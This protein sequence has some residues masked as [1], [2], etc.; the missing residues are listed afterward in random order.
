MRLVSTFDVG[1]ISVVGFYS[2]WS[3]SFMPT[4]FDIDTAVKMTKPTIKDV[5]TIATAQLMRR[6]SF[7]VDL[8]LGLS[9]E[10]IPGL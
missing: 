7:R 3:M 6:F 9:E 8:I 5:T 2:R 1:S 4:G 10:P